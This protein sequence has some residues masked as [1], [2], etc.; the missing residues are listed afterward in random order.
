MFPRNPACGG[1][2]VGYFA[3]ALR[4]GFSA[5]MVATNSPNSLTGSAP[6]ARTMVTNSTTSMRRSPPSYLAM[7][8]CGRPSF[9][10]SACCL[11]PALFRAATR[12]AMSRPYSGD[13]RDFCMAAKTEESAAQNLIP[14][15]DYPRTGYFLWFEVTVGLERDVERQMRPCAVAFL[16]TLMLGGC[17]ATSGH[18]EEQRRGLQVGPAQHE[19]TRQTRWVSA[20]SP[21]GINVCD[22]AFIFGDT[23]CERVKSGKFVSDGSEPKK[24][25]MGSSIGTFPSG[26][27]H[28]AIFSDGRTGFIDD[29]EFKYE[30]TTHDP[31][32]VAADCKRRGD[33]KIGMTTKEVIATCWGRPH[34]V[35]RTENSNV[36]SDQFVYG[37]GRYV[38]L[39]NGVVRSVQIT[40]ALR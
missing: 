26:E 27:M 9:L 13:L 23:R 8:D 7:N 34:H 11:T 16:G 1:H 21:L 35:N 37:N 29:I 28:H 4:L 38:Y 3:E 36:I 18:T 30:T 24:F 2:Q 25:R 17:T 14:E 19:T 6:S 39:E 22:E 20:S 10:A 15:P 40:G 32:L 33:P 5:G 12:T 31:A